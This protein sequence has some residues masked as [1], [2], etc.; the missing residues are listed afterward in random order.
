MIAFC[1]IPA[2]FAYY[3]NCSDIWSNIGNG[4]CFFLDQINNY[5]RIVPKLKAWIFPF[6]NIAL[7]MIVF[8]LSLHQNKSTVISVRQIVQNVRRHGLS[9]FLSLDHI[10]GIPQDFF[11]EF[12]N[13]LKV[14][15][16]GRSQSSAFCQN[17]TVL[18]PIFNGYEHLKRLLP[19]IIERSPQGTQFILI[20]DL[21]TDAAV[22]P[23]ISGIVKK[24]DKCR[25]VLNEKNLGFVKTVNKGMAMVETPYAIIANT[26]IAVP[27]DWVPRIMHPFASER[28]IASATPFSNSAVFFSFPKR[29][30]DN[31]LIPPFSLDEVDKA[32][33]GIKP[34]STPECQTHS[35]VGFCMAIDMACWREI[36]PFDEEAFGK[37]YGEETDWCMRADSRGWKNVL[38]PN[39]FVHHAH[40]GSF[41]AAEKACLCEEHIKI[42]K[43][44]WPRQIADMH[45][46]MATDPW[47]PYRALAALRLA[48]GG[49]GCLLLIDWHGK[50]AGARAYRDFQLR[51][52]KDEGWRVVVLSYNNAF[53]SFCLEMEFIDIDINIAIQ[54]DDI[55]TLFKIIEIKHL[56]INNFAFYPQPEELMAILIHLKA[57]YPFYLEYV[58]HDFLS[59]CPS[60]FLLNNKG[61]CGG[62]S[63]EIC[64]KCVS[65][66]KILMRPDMAKWRTAWRD[67]FAACDGIRCFSESTLRIVGDF[68]DITDKTRVCE[69][70]PLLPALAG[71]WQQPPADELPHSIAFIG[72]FVFCK[73]SSIVLELADKIRNERLP[74]RLIVIGRNDGRHTHEAIVFHGAYRR[75]E[76]PEIL[77]E[78]GVKAALFPSIWPETF[79]YVTQ[80]IMLMGLPFVCFDLGAPAERIRKCAYTD[81]EIAPEISAQSMLDALDALLARKY[82][83]QIL[84]K[85]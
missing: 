12:Q 66:H 3:K 78:Y 52:F 83:I 8:A 7:S 4:K 28:K 77:S 58:F 61:Y 46:H 65:E 59:I 74:L 17:V 34:D 47:K 85:S 44:R 21:S 64:G 27:E 9:G 71:R 72:N 54:I 37:G 22:R 79:S 10:A 62:G 45:R 26:D 33:Q 50:D 16:S 32:F 39:L 42:V 1:L 68:F 48:Q 60:I 41:M 75:Q 30:Q 35:G 20:D 51:R 6:N 14:W 57:K 73:G 82:G 70:S 5:H 56:F 23:F 2:S 36:G 15:N 63:A 31:T 76:L 84:K 11:I 67:F 43:K 55:E 24:H 40:G 29:G 69:H 19:H 25:L 80:E 38:V 81:A 18:I 53:T 49:K 13:V